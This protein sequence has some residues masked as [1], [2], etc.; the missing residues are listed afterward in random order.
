MYLKNN[1]SNF[2]SEG[3]STS[4]ESENEIYDVNKVRVP[5]S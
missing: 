4:S 2:T 3:L 5:V 1:I